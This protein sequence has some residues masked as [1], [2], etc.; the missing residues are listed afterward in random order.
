MNSGIHPLQNLGVIRQVKQV[1]ITPSSPDATPEVVDGK[2]FG[3]IAITKGFNSLEKAVSAWCPA[4][5]NL[6]AAGTSFPTMAD[7]CIVPQLYNARRFG[8]D[9]NAYPSLLSLEERCSAFPA[10]AAAAP[11]AQPDAQK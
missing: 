7:L 1:E 11:D 9:I 10:F 5:S 2:G 4:G 3:A 6:F 8:I